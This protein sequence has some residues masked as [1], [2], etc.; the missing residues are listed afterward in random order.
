ML[1]LDDELHFPFQIEEY[2]ESLQVAVNCMPQDMP[3]GGIRVILY[4]SDGAPVLNKEIM[5]PPYVSDPLSNL[6]VGG[7]Q[8]LV[9]PLRSQQG[10]C[11][12]A[13]IAATKNA[14]RVD[15]FIQD[16]VD[17]WWYP[18]EPQY[19]Q[20]ITIF[21]KIHC[22]DELA[23]SQGIEFM[24]VKCYL[25]SPTGEQVDNEDYGANLEPGGVDTVMFDF[26]TDLCTQP[27]HC[28]IYIN[29]DPDNQIEEYHELNNIGSRRVI[30][31]P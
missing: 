14:P 6:T 11:P 2:A 5:A 3:Q 26:H 27:E 28:R 30:F 13:A 10:S 24:P 23:Y 22:N 21:A 29:I 31:A 19:G 18:S 20:A 25:N 9:R 15:C 7:W 8:I 17:I 12:I 4:D 16:S 1:K